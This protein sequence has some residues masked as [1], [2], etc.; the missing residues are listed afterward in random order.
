MG[1]GFTARRDQ[2]LTNA[3][4][5]PR[6]PPRAAP[7]GAPHSLV[8]R[9]PAANLAQ[10]ARTHLAGLGDKSVGPVA[11]LDDQPRDPSHQFIGQSP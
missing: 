2:V 7:A 10:H 5:S 11:Y 4:V 3:K 9:R 6:T 1:G 8:P